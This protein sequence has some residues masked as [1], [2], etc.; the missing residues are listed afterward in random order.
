MSIHVV[1]IIMIS[2][3]CLR[4]SVL[5]LGLTMQG[6]LVGIFYWTLVDLLRLFMMFLLMVSLVV[7]ISFPISTGIVR[8][9]LSRPGVLLRLS[10]LWLL[11]MLLSILS[12]VMA[13][14]SG[15]MMLILLLRLKTWRLLVV[16]S[17][18]ILKS[19]LLSLNRLCLAVMRHR[20]CR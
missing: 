9:K 15:L 18:S 20:G 8:S 16:V 19:W 17:L 10:V 1:L 3:V 4:V 2:W 6:L 14:L 7:A 5:W 13:R 11:L 12:L